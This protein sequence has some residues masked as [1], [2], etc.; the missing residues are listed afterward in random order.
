[1][2]TNHE[3]SASRK[4]TQ[5]LDGL[6][7]AERVTHFERN[8][9]DPKDPA[10]DPPAE[11]P[12]AQKEK[13]TPA[14]LQSIT[15][16]LQDLGGVPREHT[17]SKRLDERKITPEVQQTFDIRPGRTGWVYSLPGGGY[18][19]KHYNSEAPTKYFW[20]DQDGNKASKP[21]TAILYYA[22]D[23][24]QAIDQAG[25]VC[26]LAAGEP[27]VWALR[28]AG[29][30][31]VLSGYTEAAAPDR[32]AEYLQSHGVT[33]L[34]IAPD[35]DLAGERWAG[36]IAAA[37]EASGIELDCRELPANL[38]N[39]GDIGKAWQR[40]EGKIFERYLLGLP[41][42]YPT[43]ET[44][45]FEHVKAPAITD[46]GAWQLDPLTRQAIYNKLG[47]K[48]FRNGW[49]INHVLCPFHNDHTPSANVAEAFGLYCHTCE[50]SFNWKATA[51]A[52]GVDFVSAFDASY[53]PTSYSLSG[54][55]S[56][57]AGLSIEAKQVLISAGF[58]ALARLL[59]VL[60]SDDRG[61]EVVTVL[62]LINSYSP[63][64]L[65]AYTIRQAIKQGTG[66]QLPKN[67][68]GQK[69]LMR[70]LYTSL[71]FT[72]YEVYKTLI[73]S[74]SRPRISYKMPT[75]DEI[76]AILHVETR[77]GQAINPDNLGN[78]TDYKAAVCKA[79]VMRKPGEYANKQLAKPL[80][81]HPRTAARYMRR[82]GDL[83]I[84]PNFERVPL[85]PEDIEA[86]PQDGHDLS[87]WRRERKLKGAIWIEAKRAD[88]QPVIN[89]RG[90]AVRFAPCKESIQAALDFAG[91]GGKVYQVAQLANTF[92]PKKARA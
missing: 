85:T 86:M 80:D 49:S 5:P 9:G 12:Q 90:E 54:P 48:G 20:C 28:S 43:P 27:D 69:D 87:E 84:T 14:G 64:P 3:L 56:D 13:Y 19:F 51:Q 52:L 47:V 76:H 7:M 53:T 11:K 78:A 44:E 50:Q 55:G 41:R 23:L 79:P 58:T 10:T 17:L 21:D 72:P 24:P 16:V 26:W 59:D 73:K 57:L 77:S 8:L 70:Y 81:C 71:F 34:Y 74:N 25:G 15:D 63:E 75:L 2:T 60:M 1:M 6:P 67:A 88:G 91:E 38:D 29:V 33:V 4:R 18:R 39:S 42:W 68:K 32:L 37:I 40:Y 30:Y 89:M 66:K 83:D 65:P 36:K 92:T 22:F 31:H 45:T 46:G 61:G 35:L 62:D 82:G